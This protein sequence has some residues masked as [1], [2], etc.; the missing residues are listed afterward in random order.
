MSQPDVLPVPRLLFGMF[1]ILAFWFEICLFVEFC[2]SLSC[3]LVFAH[4]NFCFSRSSGFLYFSALW[5]KLA[6]CFP[7]SFNWT[8]HAETHLAVIRTLHQQ[9]K[10]SS[11]SSC[12]QNQ[13][14][15]PQNHL[16]CPM[17]LFCLVS[18]II[19]TSRIIHR[20]GV[21][22]LCVWTINRFKTKERQMCFFIWDLIIIIR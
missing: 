21:Q 8:R 16:R 20:L 9:E 11:L 4:V 22:G 15:E 5:I 19:T 3:Y 1:W 10:L 6:F 12:F 17:N 14:E 2:F 7:I 18:W 13:M